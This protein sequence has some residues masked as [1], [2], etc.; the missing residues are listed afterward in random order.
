MPM[1]L[2]ALGSGEY[3]EMFLFYRAIVYLAKRTQS[4][5]LI[6]PNDKTSEG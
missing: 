6:F 1:G 3:W 5:P 2:A 4:T